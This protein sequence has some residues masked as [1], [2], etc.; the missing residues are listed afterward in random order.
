MKIYKI[1]TEKEMLVIA[2]NEIE[3]VKHFYEQTAKNWEAYV[4]KNTKV[5]ECVVETSVVDEKPEVKEVP[6]YLE[7][8]CECEDEHFDILDVVKDYQDIITKII[9]KEPLSK[10]EIKKIEGVINEIRA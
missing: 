7:E 1:K 8:K 6:N 3:A 10:E 9:N 5:E 4:D 2:N